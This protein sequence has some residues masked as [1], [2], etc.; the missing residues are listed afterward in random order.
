MKKIGII[1]NNRKD[2]DFLYLKQIITSLVQEGFVPV[3]TLEQ[4][5]NVVNDKCI[6]TSIEEMFKS[7][8]V[9]I[10]LGGDGTFLNVA[11][12]AVRYGVALLGVN[13]GTLGYLAQL[14]K[15][16]I[17]KITTILK[18]DYKI[19]NR[20]MITARVYRNNKIVYEYSALNDAVITRSA[21]LKPVHI[22]LL[23]ETGRIAN[24]FCDGLIFSTPT[25]SSAYSLSV[26]G[27]VMDP[28]MEAILV[29]A[30]SPHSLTGHSL[31]FDPHK[32]LGCKV[33]SP[34]TVNALISVDGRHVFYLQQDDKIEIT[35]NDKYLKLIQ[36]S[37]TDFYTVLKR[38]FSL[39]GQKI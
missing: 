34:K 15:T 26:G 36:L 2:S 37:D 22:D 28:S 33:N 18:S 4:K 38:K 19:Q 32:A 13:L 12:L 21:V 16:D 5:G 17:D 30:I 3:L 11:D 14:D 9:V 27:P 23:G 39:R 20:M 7:S 35:K 6:F 8:S 29:S 24:Y 25:G 31:V 10:I 1:V